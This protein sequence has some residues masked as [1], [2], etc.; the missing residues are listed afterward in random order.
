M[1][2]K[3]NNSRAGKV[4]VI[5]VIVILLIVLAGFIGWNLYKYKFIKGKVKT[6]VFE[7]SNG[8]YTIRYDKME[9]DEV[10]GYLHVTNL[11]II[12]DT[13]KFRQMVTDRKNP[14]LLLELTVPELK[15]SGVKTPEAMLN[16]K[17]SGRKLEVSNATVVFYYA[18]AHPDTS[19]PA[20]KQ[21]MYQ[22]L[23]GNLKEIQADTVEVTNVSLAFIDIR[24]SKKTIEASNISIHLN[25]VLIDSLHA[26]DSS[27]FFFAKQVQVNGEKG[28]VKN[29][30]GTYFYH[31]DG[32][33]FTNENG[34]FAIKSIRIEP[35]L[36]EEKFAAFSKLQD[37]R[38]NV[39]LA[40]V[41]LKNI[42]LTR[43]MESDLIAG[44]LLIKGLNIRVYR[45]LSYPRDKIVRVG[46]FPQQL[47]MDLPL[48]LS[49]K[50]II[51][52]DAFIE[53]KEKNPKSDYSG[54]VQFVHANAVISNVTNET[55]R[56]KENNHCLLDFN[57]RF[58]DMAPM[59]AHLDMLLNDKKGRFTYR[60][61]M[62]GFEASKLNV[63]MEPMGL[64]KI[65]KGQVNKVD[66]NFA[67]QNY[68]ADGKLTLLYDDL[69]I[70]LL[71][72]DSADDTF[73]KKKLASFIANIIVKNSNPT[74]HKPVRVADVHY[75][76]DTN[77]SFFNLMWKSIYTGV[78]QT[79]GM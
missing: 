79:A 64:A 23:L 24:T 40:G 61:S 67:G 74:G 70:T 10:G 11:Q 33:S 30:T 73:K 76:H 66:F 54:K 22:Q 8:L 19:D 55:G 5:I 29:K 38:F 72:K 31:F 37:D 46:T 65:D 2:P 12:P 39:S 77:R 42:N 50:K 27:R 75:Q 9:L 52:N 28:V 60:G 4:F 32:F 69:K 25:D 1:I 21:E 71:K 49:L 20:V 35:Q 59:H 34:L 68:G 3:K 47:L 58:L 26:N 48:N 13:I 51:L 36:N 18:K 17:V 62:E 44:E 43:L 41:S 15:I 7:K 14:G 53:Y 56:I 6:A 57:A 63:L 16:K 78:K 45:D